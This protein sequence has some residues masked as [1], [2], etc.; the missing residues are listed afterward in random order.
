LHTGLLSAI[1]ARGWEIG[2]EVVVMSGSVAEIVGESSP[3][4]PAD[5]VVTREADR[6]WLAGRA[7]CNPASDLEPLR[8]TVLPL[9]AGR[10][11]FCRIGDRAT[12]VAVASDG[13]VGLFALAVAPDAR[14][15]GI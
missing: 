11:H 8:R 9:L 13:L 3:G 12:G 4:V 10:A 7:R 5:F 1:T 6:D 15:Q 2:P 14:R